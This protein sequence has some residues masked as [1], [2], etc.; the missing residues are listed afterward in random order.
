M[1]LTYEEK[2]LIESNRLINKINKLYYTRE[3][4]LIYFVNET[5]NSIINRIEKS[6]ESN[7]NE[8]IKLSREFDIK[9]LYFNTDDDEQIN[10][11]NEYIYKSIEQFDNEKIKIFDYKK[12]K[13]ENINKKN[14][15]NFL[16]FLKKQIKKINI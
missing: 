13:I 15:F 16:L 6:L 3:A 8:L 4:L 12:N 10:K 5:E 11:I 2:K 1:E 7:K 14:K 9:Y